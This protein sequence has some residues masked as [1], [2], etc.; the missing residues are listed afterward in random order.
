MT[1][2]DKIIN[3]FAVKHAVS[4]IRTSPTIEQIRR[5]DILKLHRRYP[6]TPCRCYG[7]PLSKAHA[8]L[9]SD[10]LQSQL[11]I[12]TRGINPEQVIT[13]PSEIT[14]I[15]RDIAIMMARFNHACTASWFWVRK[16][17][18][19]KPDVSEDDGRGNVH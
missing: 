9:K 13:A 18:G 1:L 12:V 4:L 6:E 3:R 5:E 11:E 14:A 17:S 16:A 8:L 2:D 10:G 15:I 7:G 19:S